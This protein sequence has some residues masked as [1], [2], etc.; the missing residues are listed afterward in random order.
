MQA[1]QALGQNFL[2]HQATADRIA[3]SAGLTLESVVLEI[4]PGTGM[5]TRALLA[6]AGKVIAVE[7][8]RELIPQ[9]TEMFGPEIAEGKLELIEGDIRRFDLAQLPEGYRVVAN[10][11][12]YITGE[13]L[14]LL[15]SATHKPTS[16][17]VLVQKEVAE[18]I[19]R[20]VKE[21]LLSL[22]VK[23]YGTPAYKFTVP[24]GAFR[25]APNVDSAILQVAG[26]TSPFPT[27]AEEIR[28]FELIHAGFA[29]KRKQ[30]G[31]N[32]E[33]IAPAERVAQALEAVGL[34]PTVR[35]EDVPLELWKKMAGIV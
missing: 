5:L 26:I 25:P 6:R 20:S 23:V 15:L 18:R 3:D 19:V 14:R 28:F 30:L 1:K 35:A 7:T 2:M 12:Y 22:S 32:I 8:D 10:I 29:H 27:N 11:P 33:A 9:L 4:G 24:R 17:T 13:I 21:S 34:P 31:K 16:V